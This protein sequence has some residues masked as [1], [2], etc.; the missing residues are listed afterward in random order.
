M[1]N[2]AVLKHLINT[3]RFLDRRSAPFVLK[4]LNSAIA[5]ATQAG[6]VDA[7]SLYVKTV[8]VDEGPTAKR[9]LPRAMGRATK[10]LKRS[11]HVTVVVDE[12]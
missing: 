12:Q 4:L 8:F 6:D 5:N 3:L 11:C 10:I 2:R 9:F 7:D 1:E